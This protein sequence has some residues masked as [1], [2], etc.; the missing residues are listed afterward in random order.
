VIRVTLVLRVLLQNK[1][2]RVGLATRVKVIR[3][4]LVLRETPENNAIRVG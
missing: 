1:E 4:T 3:V 2:L